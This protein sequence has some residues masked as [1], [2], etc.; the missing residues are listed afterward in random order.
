MRFWWHGGGLDCLVQLRLVE[1]AG[2][3]RLAGVRISVVE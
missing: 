1:I 2:G 3:V